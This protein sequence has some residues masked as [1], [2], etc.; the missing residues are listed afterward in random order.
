MLPNRD[1]RQ[2]NAS[3]PYASH[4]PTPVKGRKANGQFQKGAV[5]K[6]P[7]RPIEIREHK[8]WCRELLEQRGGRERLEQW[9]LDDRPDVSLPALRGGQEY[10]SGKPSQETILSGAGGGPIGLQVIYDAPRA[11]DAEASA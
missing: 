1:M 6:S 7:G 8:V 4:N 9:A 11:A 2:A 5:A 10:A 3:A